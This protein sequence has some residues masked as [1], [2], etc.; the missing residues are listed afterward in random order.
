MSQ[1]KTPKFDEIAGSVYNT[2]RGYI[3][4]N[5]PNK[6]PKIAV[7]ITHEY[8]LEVMAEIKGGVSSYS[9]DFYE[10]R[11]IIGYP[12]FVVINQPIGYKHPPW[13][14]ILLGDKS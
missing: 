9:F 14:V 3:S 11:T 12:A 2:Y 7:Y 6:N 8:Y 5:G 1:T 13:E 4:K 10:K